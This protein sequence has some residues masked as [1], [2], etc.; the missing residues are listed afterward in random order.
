MVS[1]ANAKVKDANARLRRSV[2]GAR[3]INQLRISETSKLSAQVRQL[4]SRR[5]NGGESPSAAGEDARVEELQK[6]L[7]L[8]NEEVSDIGHCIAMHKS[9]RVSMG[10]MLSD[11]LARMTR[12]S[13]AHA[14]VLC[15]HRA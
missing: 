9:G 7:A 1:E 12:R 4:Q 11:A 6:E 8:V 10:P 5:L 3:L 15:V 13:C 14:G 2:E